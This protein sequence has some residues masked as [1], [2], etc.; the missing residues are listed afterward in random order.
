MLGCLRG[1]WKVDKKPLTDCDGGCSRLGH[2]TTTW[3]ACTTKSILLGLVPVLQLG[4]EALMRMLSVATKMWTS[5][6]R[7]ER[8]TL[9]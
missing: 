5:H 7:Y 4:M 2:D 3:A 9:C 8:P 1:L 6:L